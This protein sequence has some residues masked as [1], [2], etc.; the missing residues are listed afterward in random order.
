[1]YK[2]P[3]DLVVHML[4]S[5]DN[6]EEFSTG[7]SL[8]AF[9]TSKIVVHA[10]IANITI[11]GEAVSKMPEDFQDQFPEI[12]WFRIRGMRNRLVHDYKGINLDLLYD[13]IVN[14]LPT[15]KTQLQAILP[16]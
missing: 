11:I 14:D 5:I 8:D 3:H 6:I 4:E 15:L 16:Q 1:M 10:V 7:L 13:T 2:N 9:K 12:N